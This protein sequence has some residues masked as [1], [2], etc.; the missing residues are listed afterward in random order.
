M[1]EIPE[2]APDFDGISK[3]EKNEGCGNVGKG[4]LSDEPAEDIIESLVRAGS[5]EIGLEEKWADVTA[6]L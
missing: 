5:L 3:S 4:H 2:T 6:E 1:D